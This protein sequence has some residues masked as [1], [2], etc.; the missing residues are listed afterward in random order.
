M[1]AVHVITT[2]AAND[3]LYDMH[4]MICCGVVCSIICFS[5]FIRASRSFGQP[6]AVVLSTH[7]RLLS[8]S[9]PIR[10]RIFYYSAISQSSPL[11]FHIAMG[12]PQTHKCCKGC[13]R[14]RSRAQFSTWQWKENQTFCLVG[15]GRK[16]NDPRRKR[17]IEFNRESLRQSAKG[18]K[19]KLGQYNAEAN[20][21]KNE[22][23]ARQ[24]SKGKQRKLGQ[25]NAEANQTKNRDSLR[26]ASKGE[27]RKLGQYNAEANQAK[28]GDS[29]RQASKGKQRKLG[30]YNAEAN[31][32][33]NEDSSR[34]ASKG[35]QRELGQYNAEANRRKNA[36][37]SR[38]SNKG[39]YRKLG[40]YNTEANRTKNKDSAR[41]A[42]KGKQRKLGDYN[43]IVL[44]QSAERQ[45]AKSKKTATNL[46]TA[47]G[48]T[49][50]ILYN[51]ARAAQAQRKYV[52][53]MKQLKSL[54]LLN[55]SPDSDTEVGGSS[56]DS[57]SSSAPSTS[58]SD[59]E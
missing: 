53:T 10:D 11:E 13:N 1:C 6:K 27:Q 22:N 32:K 2:T 34:Q 57:D 20:L 3:V 5:R 51:S 40:Q 16:A 43:T 56:T 18:K 30:Q 38:Q 25:Y 35:K 14:S 24:A 31:R 46:R 49:A 37:S 9:L 41:Q 42:E 19:R 48:T 26:Q 36:D 52:A 39:K 15:R 45:R 7:L 4:F 23:S 17:C 29:S 50:L 33:K 54:G 21:S 8:C 44:N 28:N 47:N 55:T 12:K 58:D 59:S